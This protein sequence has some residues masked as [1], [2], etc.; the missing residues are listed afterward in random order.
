MRRISLLCLA[1]VLAPVA[2]HAD[3]GDAPA[4]P[5]FSEVDSNNDLY[6]DAA[7]LQAFM[8]HMREQAGR[9]GRDGRRPS[10]PHGARRGGPIEMA[11]A[12]GDGMLNEQEYYDLLIRMEEMRERFRERRR[13]R[14]EGI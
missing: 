6:V 7:E 4:P 12:D 2:A 5:S 11:D 9:Q 14:G 8:E 10:M 13:D 3:D 1:I